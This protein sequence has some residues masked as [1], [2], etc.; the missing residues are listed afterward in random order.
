[1]PKTADTLASRF[2]LADDPPKNRII[3][4]GY[5]EPGSGKTS[6]A[7][8]A[9]GP[10]LFLS[11]DRGLEGVIEKFQ[12]EKEIFVK[13]YDWSPAPGAQLEQTAA[14]D[15]RDEFIADIEFGIKTARS[16]IIDKESDMWDLFKYAEFGFS[17]AG[18]P[19]NW[20]GLKARVRR[21]INMAKTTDVN[22]GLIQGMRN[23]WAPGAVNQQTGKK[24]IVQTGRRIRAGMDEIEGLVHINLF[25]QRKKTDGESEFSIEVGKARGPGSR[26]IQDQTFIDV[27]FKTLASLTFPESDEADWV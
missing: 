1:M 15:L 22:F 10:I 19:K 7:L 5:G 26:D 25:H 2:T 11:F 16:V 14:E 17:E 27:D 8:G 3:W 18:A 23:E 24:G 12:A 6:F 21:I 4:A 9:P 20:D 13:E